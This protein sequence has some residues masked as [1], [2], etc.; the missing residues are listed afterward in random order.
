V[1]VPSAT[2]PLMPSWSSTVT[3]RRLAGF[4]FAR[5]DG[6][7]AFATP[8]RFVDAPFDFDAF[9][10]D[11]LGF[12]ALGFALGFDVD[13]G[14]DLDAF[15]FDAFLGAD[16]AFDFDAF[17][18]AICSLSTRYNDYFFGANIPSLYSTI[19]PETAE[20][21]TVSGDAR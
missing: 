16:A 13:L 5:V 3:R 9:G 6:P 8:P 4:A 1:T 14:F 11:A 18:R 19:S 17:A 7:R 21:A 2:S 12:D 20:A 10:F 15:G